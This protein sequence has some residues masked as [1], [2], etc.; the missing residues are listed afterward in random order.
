MPMIKAPEAH[1]RV[2]KKEITDWA[3]VPTTE[4][5]ISMIGVVNGLVILTSPI[6]F[7]KKGEVQTM[8][9]HY[10]LGE[11]QPGLWELKLAVLRPKHLQMLSDNEIL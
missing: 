1:H 5:T 2:E 10:L 9:S 7:V 6:R 4:D 8:N 3:I 11:K